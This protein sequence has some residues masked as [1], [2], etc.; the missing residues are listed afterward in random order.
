MPA[1]ACLGLTHAF[2]CEFRSGFCAVYSDRNSVLL[3]GAASL[4]LKVPPVLCG[5]H[6]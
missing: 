1:S 5:Y 6:G 3:P 2:H 4:M